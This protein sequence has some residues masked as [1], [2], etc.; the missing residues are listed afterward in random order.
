MPVRWFRNGFCGL[1]RSSAVGGRGRRW[2]TLGGLDG[3]AL[4][5]RAWV[6][7][8]YLAELYDLGLSVSDGW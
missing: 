5:V 2:Y 6:Q 1:K 8:M 7:L 4:S 3:R